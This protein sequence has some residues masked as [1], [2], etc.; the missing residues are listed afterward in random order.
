MIILG[1]EKFAKY[2]NDVVV[3]KE[4]NNLP[5]PVC[6]HIDMNILKLDNTLFLPEN[7]YLAPFFEQNGFSVKYI[8]ETLGNTYPFDVRLNAKQIGN[9]VLMN[10]KTISKDVLD[11]C[12]D[13]NK[14]IIDVSQGYAACS[15]LCIS[16]TAFITADKGIFN[17]L[18]H[19]GASP[20]LIKEGYI[21]IEE[22]DYGFIGGASGFIGE[23]L[24]FFGDITTHP[25]FEKIDEYLTERNVEYKWFDSPLTDIGGC[26]EI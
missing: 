13:A 4:N 6:T 24:Y 25:D 1:N 3:L 16:E 12:K 15:T 21:D 10:T 22:Y 19:H 2:F 20:L 17:A 11:F 7:H 9:L 23:T 26:L 5:K 18:K 8:S 14:T